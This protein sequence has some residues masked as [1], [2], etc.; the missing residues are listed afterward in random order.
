MANSTM[1]SLDE[2]QVQIIGSCG[3]SLIPLPSPNDRTSYLPIN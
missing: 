3:P 1:R 2:V